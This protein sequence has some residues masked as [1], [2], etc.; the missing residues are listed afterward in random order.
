MFVV[1]LIVAFVERVVEYLFWILR[2]SRPLWP[3]FRV[4]QAKVTEKRPK[5]IRVVLNVELAFEKVLNLL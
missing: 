1:W 4:G 3:W 5:I 2:S